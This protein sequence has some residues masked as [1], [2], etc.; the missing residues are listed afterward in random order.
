MSGIIWFILF[1]V[2][3]HLMHRGSG[4]GGCGMGHR[5]GNHRDSGDAAQS[6][7][8]DPNKIN[9][10]GPSPHQTKPNFDT[11]PEAEFEVLDEN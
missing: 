2:I 4:M 9:N 8:A 5:H 11:L 7:G 10:S 1:M 6:H 3:M